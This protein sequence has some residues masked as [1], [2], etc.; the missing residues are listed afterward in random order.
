VAMYRGICVVWEKG[1]APVRI[2]GARR[3]ER[4]GRRGYRGRR[5]PDVVDEI[6]GAS[7]T[8]SNEASRI[9]VNMQALSPVNI[10]E[11]DWFVD[12]DGTPVKIKMY[13]S[14]TYE[15][16]RYSV[17]NIYTACNYNTANPCGNETRSRSD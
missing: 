12:A 4:R 14:L 10:P 7:S 6:E 17:H 16:A 1:F 9:T 13:G 3:K 11:T 8:S 15:E 2:P 5:A